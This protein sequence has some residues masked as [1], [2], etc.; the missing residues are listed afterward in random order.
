MRRRGAGNEKERGGHA[1]GKDDAGKAADRAGHGT[2][3]LGGAKERGEPVDGPSPDVVA[4]RLPVPPDP[5]P[6][7]M[8]PGL[9]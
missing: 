8:S 7:F 9:G 4:L 1:E 3:I 2:S 5:M 6:G